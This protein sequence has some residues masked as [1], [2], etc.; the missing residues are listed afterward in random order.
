M[1]SDDEHKEDV[2]MRSMS[3]MLCEGGASSSSSTARLKHRSLATTAARVGG[4]DPS[5]TKGSQT[6]HGPRR[7]RNGGYVVTAMTMNDYCT[8][9]NETTHITA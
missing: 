7:R 6:G 1:S 3:E 8:Y 4:A 2:M 5:R 9:N